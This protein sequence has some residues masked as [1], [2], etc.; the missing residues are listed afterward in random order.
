HLV[1]PRREKRRRFVLS[2]FS[3]WKT[4]RRLVPAP[5][6]EA[7]SRPRSGRRGGALSRAG[8]RG[9]ASF[10]RGE[11]SV[12]SSY[13]GRR[14]VASSLRRETTVLMVPPGS[15]RSAYRYPIG[16]MENLAKHINKS[17]K[18]VQV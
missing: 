4:K 11:R 12:A 6:D 7:A 10:L 16:E 18:P 2:C 9:V 15:G 1:L 13:T 3:R 5:E 17:L 14:G 8:R